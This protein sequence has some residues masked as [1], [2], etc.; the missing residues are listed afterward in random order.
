MNKIT[1]PDICP[2][3]RTVSSN[4]TSGFPSKMGSEPN[5]KGP[6]II[7]ASNSPNT[8]GSFSLLKISANI[9]AATWQFV[10]HI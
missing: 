3:C 7:P 6:T 5:A 2:I 8:A 1:I 4:M 10:N 9:F